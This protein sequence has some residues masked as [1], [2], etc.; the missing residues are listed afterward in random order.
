MQLI[1]SRT[2]PGHAYSDCEDTEC[3]VCGSKYSK[4][5]VTTSTY[6]VKMT[7]KVNGRYVY[8]V[9]KDKYGKTVKTVTVRVKMK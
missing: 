4:S 8:C 7:S 5:S 9:V 3:N 6:S 2:A 1:C